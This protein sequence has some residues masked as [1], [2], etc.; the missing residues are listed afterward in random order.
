MRI[1]VNST[2]Q[3]FESCSQKKM[4]VESLKFF[5]PPTTKRRPCKS[6]AKLKEN[7]LLMAN[8]VKLHEDYTFSLMKMHNM[9]KI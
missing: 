1:A 3:A 4:V 8:I 7:H 2:T 5:G 6:F 9:S